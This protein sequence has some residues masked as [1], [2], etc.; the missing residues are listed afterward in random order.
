MRSLPFFIISALLLLLSSCG[1]RQND[2]V[3]I[4]EAN[5][6]QAIQQAIDQTI[7]PASQDFAEQT[8]QMRNLAEEFCI[9]FDIDSLSA[10]QNQWRK[11][12][13]SWYRLANFN[14]GP[15]NDDVI[16]PTFTFID[17][18]RLRGIDY[19]ASVREDTIKN[20]ESTQDLN[21]SYFAGLTYQ[22]VGLLPL[23]VALF[24]TAS[25]LPS[26]DLQAIVSDFQNNPR[27]CE[28]VNG[29]TTELSRH[30]QAI[31]QEWLVDFNDSGK[32][33]RDLFLNHQLENGTE[34]LTL[35]LTSVQEYL[36]Y[37]R[38]RNV[39]SVA[40]Q[41]S[42]HSRQNMA[43]AV[44]T[45]SQL[46]NGSEKNPISFFALMSASGNHSAVETVRGNLALAQESLTEQDY[47]RL[48]LALSQ[49]DGNFKRE[50][51]NS[52]NV[53]LGINFSDGD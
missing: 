21:S 1:T 48:D 17:A 7:I 8:V 29:L 33:F 38:K 34:P 9:A 50:I 23:E 39:V 4:S 41:V 49:L 46:L 45:I 16:F 47:V 30:G 37:L 18:L 43:A 26:R 35:L 20:L 24:E 31:E 2:A 19:L 28:I 6:E 10:A 15:L 44:D 27:K 32:A 52:L 25:D 22:K 36:D 14:F 3:E 13:E 53:E 42:E 51:P 40:A 11:T 5:L 12:S